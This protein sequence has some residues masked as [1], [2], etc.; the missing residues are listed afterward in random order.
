MLLQQK[1]AK[2]HLLS[3]TRLDF[4]KLDDKFSII[5]KAMV[6]VELNNNTKFVVKF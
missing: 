4:L 3:Q 6:T 2:F 1:R 5:V